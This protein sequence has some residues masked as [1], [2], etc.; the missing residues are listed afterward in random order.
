MF[1]KSFHYSGIFVVIIIL[2]GETIRI[3]SEMKI[4]GPEK[5]NPDSKPQPWWEIRHNEMFLFYASILNCACD[6]RQAWEIFMSDLLEFN[7]VGLGSVG[8]IIR[9]YPS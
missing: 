7:C 1:W 6:S 8:I 5:V 9:L 4:F 2:H 3:E